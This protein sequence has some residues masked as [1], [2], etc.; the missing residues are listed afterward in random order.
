M[1]R[2]LVAF[3]GAF[4]VLLIGAGLQLAIGSAPSGA[5]N[6][7][8][9]ISV[10]PGTIVAGTTGNTLNFSY[11][12]GGQG[13]TNGTLSVKVPKGWTQPQKNAAG[14]PGDVAVNAGKVVIS[15]RLITVRHL[16]L[17]RSTCML[18]LSYSDV[19][20]PATPGTAT[21]P[22]RAAKSGEPLELLASAPS[23]VI[24]ESTGCDGLPS[25]ASNGSAT[26]T[27]TPGTCLNDG[28]V[29]TLTASGFDPSSIG[30]VEQCNSDPN[31]PLVTM[32]ILGSQETLP[33]S[34]SPFALSRA[35]STTSTGTFPAG[36]TFTVAAGTVGPPCGAPGDLAATCPSDS[37][38]GNPVSDAAN[39]PCPPSAAEVAAGVGP[40]TIAFGDQ[41]GTTVTAPILFEGE[42]T[43]GCP[44]QPSTAT[45]GPATMTVT[46]GTC[47]DGGSVVTLTGSG[48]DASSIGIV[49]QC[50]SDPSQPTVT[51][52]VLGTPET[53]PISCSALA[54]SRAVST[55]PTGTLPVS[56]NPTTFVVVAGTVGPP[57]GA[58]G[59]LVTTCPVDST[60]GNTIADAANYPCPPTPAEAAAGVTCTLSYGDQKGA[61]VTVPIFYH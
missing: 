23:V 13:L 41:A 30:I 2:I 54:L 27:I 5:A 59:D 1:H 8:G 46:P 57:C 47:L 61:S 33:V 12:P 60:G 26:M 38:G 15:N 42:S 7:P 48:F 51:L 43:T 55:T 20:A 21:F 31:Q 14:V 22:T 10:S 9:H 18:T 28:S 50:N 19:T 52:S 29:V 37:A 40:C 56:P 24:S 35:V 17:C 6:P 58:E 16:T 34:C 32:N 3:R 4:L 25:T 36:A 53:L 11:A 45:N 44:G 49:Q 39:Y